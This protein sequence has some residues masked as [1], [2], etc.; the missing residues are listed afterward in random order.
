M[1]PPLSWEEALAETGHTPGFAA[2]RAEEERAAEKGAKG[3]LVG[4]A[5]GPAPAVS[6]QYP[7][8]ARGLKAASSFKAASPSMGHKKGDPK[9]GV[10]P[11]PQRR[12][13]VAPTPS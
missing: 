4:S 7:D 1:P 2:R 10:A 6:Y 13:S 11:K 3:K 12:A 8:K 5:D 9:V